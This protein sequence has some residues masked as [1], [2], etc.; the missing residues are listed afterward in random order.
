MEANSTSF[1]YF[2]LDTIQVGIVGVLLFSIGFWL[3]NL[4]SKKLLKKMAKM[5]KKIMDLNTELL[6][7][8]K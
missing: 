2:Q 8:A 6:Y 5:E 3:G 4:K 1:L 7:G